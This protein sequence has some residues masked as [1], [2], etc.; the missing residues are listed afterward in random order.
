M[1]SS[2]RKRVSPSVPLQLLV[3]NADGSSFTLS[4]HLCYDFNALALVEEATGESMLGGKIFENLTTSRIGVLFWAAVQ[5]HNP[6]YAGEEGLHQLRSYL[7]FE[8]IKPVQEAITE[9]F[10]LSLPKV[11]GEAIR[12]RVKAEATGA[13]TET[14]LPV[15]QVTI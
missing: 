4:F 6:E 11:Q 15:E 13:K 9:A 12:E 3:G 14:P 7:D 2:L 5:Q 1:K 10:I 8:N